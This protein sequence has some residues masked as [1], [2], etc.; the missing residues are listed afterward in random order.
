MSLIDHRPTVFMTIKIF[1]GS[2]ATLKN[3]EFKNPDHEFKYR[4]NYADTT[5]LVNSFMHFVYHE[6][7]K[8]FNVY[9]QNKTV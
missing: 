2:D 6:F 3:D 4:F 5:S 8:I 9:E 1:K 7:E